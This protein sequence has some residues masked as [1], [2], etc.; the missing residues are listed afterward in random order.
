MSKQATFEVLVGNIGTV[1]A[2]NNYMTAQ[3]IYAKYVKASKAGEG[4]AA[5][6]PVT[7]IHN[8]AVRMEYEG[9]VTR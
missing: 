4:R 3:C 6:E 7:L 1:H 5:G 8:G 9:T 2:G